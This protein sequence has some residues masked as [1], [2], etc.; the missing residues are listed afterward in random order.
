MKT[1]KKISIN[2]FKSA[3][4]T[5]QQSATVKGGYETQLALIIIVDL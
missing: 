4:I 5:K 2:D 1:Q 3:V